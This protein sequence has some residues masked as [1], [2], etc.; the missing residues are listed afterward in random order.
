MKKLQSL[1]ILIFFL[2]GVFAQ[3]PLVKQWDRRFGGTSNEF[4]KCFQQTADKGY[5]LGGF[6]YSGISGDKTQ[7]SNGNLDY[8]IVKTDSLGNLQW[9][10]DFGGSDDDA[11]Y[12]IQQTTDGGYIL[13]GTSISGVSG[14][15]TKPT[16]GL[17]DYWIIKTDSLGNKQW[18]K[19][20]GGTS[21][22]EFFSL[23]QTHDGGFILGGYSSSGI[24]GDKSQPTWGAE[25]FW[26]IKT[27]SLGNKKWDKDFGGTDY[28]VLISLQQTADRG[29]IL[30]GRS[31]SGISGDKAQPTWG[32]ED[33]WIVKI[34]SIGNK[35]W[36]KDFGGIFNDE[37]FFIR[38]T[39]DKGYVLG[40][41][42]VSGISGD[43]TQPTWGDADYW[44]VKV[45]SLGNK[46]WDRDFGGTSSDRVYKISQTT[47]GGYLISGD[48]YSPVSGDKTENNLG[49]L[50]TWIVK[51]DSTGNKQWDK[52]LHTPG[53]DEDGQ[54]TETDNGC[55]TMA[56]IS[57]GGIG[58]Y[59]TQPAW[60]NSNDYWLIKFC[61]TTLIE[62]IQFAIFNL[63][64]VISISPNPTDEYSL[65]SY[66]FSVGNVLR[67]NDV[68]GKT[69]FTKTV[70]S[71]ASSF[72]LQTI[73]YPRGIY[74]VEVISENSK[75]VRKVVKQ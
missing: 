11:L 65:I 61:D 6:S 38:Q 50:Q 58:G 44:I 29:Y 43:K 1:F 54:A 14:D 13:G 5:I 60:N 16:W 21:N 26:I 31:V 39:V 48:S 59:K 68:M 40:G 7:P 72:K 24:S 70:V 57:D 9:D 41:W 66:P 75:A 10:K 2:N 53:L 18:D 35:Q 67:V 25:D 71:P 20:F 62:N 33:Y 74:F 17:Y 32:A 12:S 52:T 23:Q 37:L 27:D 36:D 47:D 8:W 55:Y 49:L 73:H 19:D 42:S 69:I 4:L 46:Q 34:D 51:T 45:D 3:A 56:N 64:S 63:Q 30:G 22:D 28:D 15:K